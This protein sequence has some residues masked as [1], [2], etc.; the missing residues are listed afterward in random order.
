M[1]EKFMVVGLIKHELQLVKGPNKFV[2]ANQIVLLNKAMDHALEVQGWCLMN[3]ISNQLEDLRSSDLRNI[4]NLFSLSCVRCHAEFPQ[5]LSTSVFVHIFTNL[6]TLRFI[7]KDLS[8]VLCG[9]SHARNLQFG[10]EFVLVCDLIV[11]KVVASGNMLQNH[12]I[13][14]VNWLTLAVLSKTR[15]GL[16]SPH[17][18]VSLLVVNANFLVARVSGEGHWG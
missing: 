13:F 16:D 5:V 8:L 14:D 4:S 9:G 1:A 18:V 7:K 3:V 15:G 17:S 6:S 10:S 11:R 2:K 12:I